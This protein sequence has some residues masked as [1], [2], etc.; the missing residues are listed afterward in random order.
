MLGMTGLLGLILTIVLIGMLV[1]RE[2]ATGTGETTVRLRRTLN[3]GVA[4]LL[5]AFAVIALARVAD[6]L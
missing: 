1:S 6:V 3:I 2:L 4:P 5:V